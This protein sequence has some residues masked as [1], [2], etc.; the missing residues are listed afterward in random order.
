[1]GRRMWRRRQLEA[2]L[3]ECQPMRNRHGEPRKIIKGP[4]KKVTPYLSKSF[5][6]ASSCINITFMKSMKSKNIR[7]LWGSWCK[8]KTKICRQPT[9][10][11]SKYLTINCLKT[12]WSSRL[13]FKTCW[14]RY[15]KHAKIAK[16]SSQ[17]LPSS[18]FKSCT[19]RAATKN[20][21]CKDK[22][23]SFKKNSRLWKSTTKENWRK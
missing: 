12:I 18:N 8:T 1:M 2:A 6:P 20:K 9:L 5:I 15:L 3:A 10:Q 23:S 7:R 17:K 4:N 16:V 19:T 22:T 13:F 14:H 11:P 21:L